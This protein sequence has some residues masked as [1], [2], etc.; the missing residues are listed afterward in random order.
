MALYVI[1]RDGRKLPF[2]KSKITKA[3]L[4]AF[5]DVDA[6]ISAYAILKADNIADYIEAVAEESDHDLS[7]E[8]I[9]ELV[10]NGL[11]STKRKDVARSY[12]LYREKRTRER[13]KR[14]VLIQEIGEKI[15]ASN[16]QNQNA[17][18]DELSFGGRRGE[19][20]NTLMKDYALN[21]IVSP[22]SRDNHL[23]N[24]IYIHDFRFHMR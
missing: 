3:V 18:V 8:E 9:Q 11:M 21:Y 23:N 17:N 2:D 15:S 10:E 4:S 16:V 12:I 19:A 6:D 1:K 20:T 13:S 24:E 22:M 14:T 7:I 5:Q